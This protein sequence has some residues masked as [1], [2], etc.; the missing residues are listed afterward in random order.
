MKKKLAIMCIMGAIAASLTACGNNTDSSDAEA[1]ADNSTE[2]SDETS[3]E[4]EIEWVSD[5]EDYVNVEDMDI[6]KY[7]TLCDY[8]NMTVSAVKP[9][10][11]DAS[12]ESYINSYLLVDG[13]VTNRAVDSGDVANIDYEGK[14]DGEAFSGG[15][16]QGYNLVI[17]SGSFI[18]GFEDGLIGVMPGETVDL[19]L[20]FP[21]DYSNTDLAGQEAVF[22]VTVNYISEDAEYSSIT[23][24]DLQNMGF[25]Y[26]SLD[27]LWETGKAAVDASNDETYTSNAKN[28]IYEKLISDSEAIELP[29]W[30]VDEQMQYYRLYLEDM[31]EYYYGIDFETYITTYTDETIEEA[32][33]EMQ[34]ACEEVTKSFLVLEAVARA[35]GIS[36]SKDEVVSQAEELYSYYGYESAE[37]F[38][39]YYGF[40][41]TSYR[42]SLLQ[43]MVLDEL[44]D[45]VDVTP[46]AATE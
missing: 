44:M 14:I 9:E 33:A 7:L 37:D 39:R 11:D 21:D 36:L 2:S 1:S 40:G 38:M 42:M 3:T 13:K 17:G 23:D 32:E 31:A 12:I 18:E 24:D 45:I 15:T 26:A 30:L 27:E 5:R 20:T 28:S 19:N 4:E 34:E 35:Q 6:D 43:D 46:E 8:K 16:A 25:D 29:Q 22:T 41:Y 10:T